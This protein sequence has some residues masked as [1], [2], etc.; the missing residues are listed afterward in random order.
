MGMYYRSMLIA[1]LV[2]VGLLSGCTNDVDETIK[3]G[4]G[5]ATQSIGE[6][7]GNVASEWSD[8]LKRNGIHKEI[9]LTQKVDPS[10]SILQL[11]NEVGN[12]EVKGTSEDNITVNATI[13]SLD[14]SSRDDKYQEMMD[15]AEIAVV[16][17]GDQMEIVTHPKGNEKLNMWKWAKK[18]YGFSNFSIDYTVEIPDK[19]NSYDIS[20]EVGEINLSHLKGIYDVH[21]NVGSISIEGAH[22]QGESKVESETG[23]LQL[24]IDQMEGES[25][26]DVRTE[27]GS[28]D[29]NLAE[30]LQCSLKTKTEVGVI[31]G[32]N[33]GESDINGGGPLLSLTSSVGSITVN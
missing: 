3:V 21:N 32:A 20:S 13:W 1:A 27:V 19:V 10:V 17:H 18:E 29:A 16:I 15:N 11:D 7:V 24:S 6:T 12:I 31:T 2:S 9:S 25:S 8:E 23:S 22:I 28:I 5:E 30:S 26:L 33:K 4:I 14:K